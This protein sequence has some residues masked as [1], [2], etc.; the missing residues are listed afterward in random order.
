[1]CSTRVNNLVPNM[2]YW[3]DI[4]WNLFNTVR[5]DIPIHFIGKF[6]RL[7]Y[8]TG[9]THTYPSGLVM[10][11]EPG[12]TD[13]IFQD[14]DGNERIV[15]SMNKFYKRYCPSLFDIRK[16]N[17][18]FQL[19]KHI[20]VELRRIITSYCGGS[21]VVKSIRRKKVEPNKKR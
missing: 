12:R 11:R 16:K 4:R 2:E 18:I 21:K 17:Y 1:M 5:N 14:M 20:P 3:V 13:V 15:S 8:V 7:S 19:R 6:V 9:E 10:I